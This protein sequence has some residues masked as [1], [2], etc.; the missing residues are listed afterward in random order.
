MATRRARATTRQPR[1][2]D[3]AADAADARGGKG[4]ASTRE[5]RRG[6]L[7]AEKA[8]RWPMCMAIAIEKTTVVRGVVVACAALA[9]AVALTLMDWS[10]DGAGTFLRKIRWALN[11]LSVFVACELNVLITAFVVLF[12]VTYAQAA[13]DEREGVEESDTLRLLKLPAIVAEFAVGSKVAI[14]RLGDV[15]VRDFSLFMVVYLS[16]AGYWLALDGDPIDS[17]VGASSVHEM[18]GGVSVHS[19]VQ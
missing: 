11:P 7:R 16:F 12:P 1:A 15:I 17:G 10:D 2:K 18:E 8:A 3:A 14:A 5:P 9:L 13:I 19:L 6:E 4:A